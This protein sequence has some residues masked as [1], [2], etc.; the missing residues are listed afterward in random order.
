VKLHRSREQYPTPEWTAHQLREAFPWDTA[1]RFVLRDRD[2][3]FGHES[4]QQLKAMGVKQV[5]STPNAPR[6]RAYI[7]RL[8]GT[9]RPRMPRSCHR[10]QREQPSPASGCVH[11][12][13]PSEPHAL[14]SRKGHTEQTTDPTGECRKDSGDPRGRRTAS[15]LRTSRRL[16]QCA[17]Q[18]SARSVW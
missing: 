14:E 11:R 17:G 2:S 18:R 4:V 15:S 10:V 7:E 9:I 5:L 6:Q 1:P 12:V 13:L 8:I 3:I 16:K